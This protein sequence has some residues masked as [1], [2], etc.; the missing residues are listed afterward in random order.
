M[1]DFKTAYQLTRDAEGGY[2]NNSADRGKETY[3]GISRKNFPLWP[4]WNTIDSYQ[5]SNIFLL[6]QQLNA[7]TNLQKAVQDFYKK[8]FWDALKLDQVNNEKIAQELFDTGVNMG[9]GTAGL[10]LQRALNVTNKNATLYPDLKLDGQIGAKTIATLNSH[11]KPDDLFKV[12]N[13]LQGAKYIAICE[14]NPSQE[15]FLYGWLKR[16]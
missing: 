1:A 5:S 7:D 10:F 12:L 11:P 13:T 8:E 14:A 15:V 6:N 9:I 2:S 4:G 3:K 16:S